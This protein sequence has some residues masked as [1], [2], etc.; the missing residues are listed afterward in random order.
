MRVYDIPVRDDTGNETTLAPYKGQV[1]LIVNTATQCGFTPQYEGLQ[2]L[3]NTYHE[4]GFTVLDFPS[5]QFGE[6]AP[7]S[8]EDINDFCAVN[9]STTF[10]RFMKQDVNGDAQSPLF[11]FLKAEKPGLMGKDIKWNFTKFLVDREGR[12][13]RRYAP[14]TL[15][16]DIAHDIEALL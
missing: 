10:P 5:N 6:Q 8:M 16:K 3:Y 12:V 9:F 15:P 14:T 4:Q 1:M 7:G 11:G 13:V 2:S